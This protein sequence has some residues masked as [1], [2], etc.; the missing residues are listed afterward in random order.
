MSLE[1]EMSAGLDE[2][3]VMW[4]GGVVSLGTN[5]GPHLMLTMVKDNVGRGKDS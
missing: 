3:F 2:G 1:I 4:A 5:R